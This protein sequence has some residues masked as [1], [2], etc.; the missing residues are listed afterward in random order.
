MK[1][2]LQL[3]AAALLLANS[4]AAQTLPAAQVPAAVT[5][6]FRHAYPRV[7]QVTWEKEGVNYEAGFKQGAAVLSVLI[8]PAGK[9]VETETGLA[10]SQL[11]V[12]VRQALARQYNAYRVTEAAKI[13]SAGTGRVV[14]EAEISQGRQHR[15][16]LFTAD[17][18]PVAR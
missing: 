6:T 17:G 7:A 1:T 18:Q 12:L 8:T 14:Y 5:A 2:P 4:A 9:L 10:P 13:V 3:L 11:P 16:V 15:D